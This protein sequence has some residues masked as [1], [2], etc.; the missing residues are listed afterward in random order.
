MSRTLPP[1]W[2][3]TRTRKHDLLGNPAPASQQRA[4]LAPAVTTAGN[5]A[6]SRSQPVSKPLSK[7]AQ[8]QKRVVIEESPEPE[9]VTEADAARAQKRRRV[10]ENQAAEA[11]AAPPEPEPLQEAQSD[12]WLV[13]IIPNLSTKST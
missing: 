5:Q 12:N 7:P 8:T 1:G 10:E 3:A 2:T 11:V 6:S 9:R 13:R 4:K